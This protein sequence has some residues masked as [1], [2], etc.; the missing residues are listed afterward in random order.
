METYLFSPIF[1]PHRITTICIP[2]IRAL[3]DSQLKEG[4]VVAQAGRAWEYI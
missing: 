2:N 1:V 4:L 3:F